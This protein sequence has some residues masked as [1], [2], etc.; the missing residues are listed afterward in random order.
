VLREGR[1]AGELAQDEISQDAIMQ[2]AAGR[3]TA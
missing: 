3:G 2:R 1:V